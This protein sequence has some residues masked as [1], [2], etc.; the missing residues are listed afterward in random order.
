MELKITPS[1]QTIVKA[2][3]LDPV[4]N[5]NSKLLI[6]GAI[7]KGSSFGTGRGARCGKDLLHS[8]EP[9]KVPED[10]RLRFHD[11]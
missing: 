2:T 11:D 7:S 9:T 5:T 4:A 1:G 6:Y 10:N 3:A 8:D